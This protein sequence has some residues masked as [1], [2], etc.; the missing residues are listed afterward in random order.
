[1]FTIPVNTLDL[2]PERV[3]LPVSIEAPAGETD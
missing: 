2:V 1:V 3:E